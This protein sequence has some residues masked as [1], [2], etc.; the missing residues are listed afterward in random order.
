[1]TTSSEGQS[2]K[3]LQP[4]GAGD[5]ICDATRL[6][7]DVLRQEESIRMTSR[8]QPVFTR[9]RSIL[10]AHASEFSVADDSA[11]RY[12]LEAQVGPAT[13]K[14]WGGKIR[15]EALPV[16]WV[17]ARKAYVSYHLMGIAGNSTLAAGLSSALRA[18]MQGKSCFNFKV[19]DDAL[20]QELARVTAESLAGMK[21]A[22]YVSDA[23]VA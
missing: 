2:Q 1:M 15:A 7:R 9:L 14:G 3:R 11:Q 13:L 16:A 19:V 10:A 22:G 4:A 23:P 21:K 20:M 5:R 6:K 8:F 18:H 12:G 17:E